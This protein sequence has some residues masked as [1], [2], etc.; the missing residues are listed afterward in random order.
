MG[1]SQFM[2]KIKLA[3]KSLD[4]ESNIWLHFGRKIDP[5][6]LYHEEVSKLDTQAL[7]NW[8][9]DVFGKVHSSKFPLVAML[10]MV[11]FDKRS[12]IH[13]NPR[14]T[15][16]GDDRHKVLAMK[17]C[18]WIDKLIETTDLTQ[19]TTARVFLNYMINLCW[20]I[21]QDCTVIIGKSA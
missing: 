9:T 1:D 17:I 2:K 11:V 3:C 4:I 13:H 15:L 10:V 8:S 18:S 6:I 12:G 16:Y 14:S 20:D 19:K 7:G 5:A 21:L